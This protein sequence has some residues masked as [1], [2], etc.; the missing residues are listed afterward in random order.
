M[1]QDK[2]REWEPRGKNE[3]ERNRGPCIAQSEEWARGQ[4]E[5]RGEERGV[6]NKEASVKPT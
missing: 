2:G 4:G 1:G 6:G 5:G 3:R